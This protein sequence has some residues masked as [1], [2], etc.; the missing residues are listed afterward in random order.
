MPKVGVDDI[1]CDLAD[2]ISG[3]EVNAEWWAL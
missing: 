3:K 1:V 2:I